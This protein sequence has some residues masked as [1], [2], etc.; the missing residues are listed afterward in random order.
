VGNDYWHE[1]ANCVILSIGDMIVDVAS[2]QF[3]VLL[4]CERRIT[5]EEDD[6]YFWYVNWIS[7]LE[8]NKIAPNPVCMEEQGLKLSIVVGFYDLHLSI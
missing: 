4:S 7:N 6:L 3:G 2:G 1:Q 8:D 5:Y